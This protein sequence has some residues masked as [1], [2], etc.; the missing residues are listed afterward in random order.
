M[1]FMNYNFGH[2]EWHNSTHALNKTIWS[3]DP[4][5]YWCSPISF[6]PV[7]VPL[8]G[9]PTQPVDAKTLTYTARFKASAAYL[10]TLFP[11]EAF[12]FA[13]PGTVGEISF[14]YTEVEVTTGSGCKH[15][16]VG[17]SLHG[18]EYHKV[19][20]SKV[21]GSFLVVLFESSDDPQSASPV[22]LGLPKVYCN[23]EAV[24]N[25]NTLIVTCSSAGN[26]FLEL[27]YEELKPVCE[28]KIVSEEAPVDCSKP[29][30][31]GS[32]GPLVEEGTLWYRYVP[33]VGGF[34]KA[35]AAYPVFAASASPR[36]PEKAQYIETG[37]GCNIKFLPGDWEGFS[38]VRH[39]VKGL[40]E[41]S[42]YEA[43]R[44]TVEKVDGNQDYRKASKIE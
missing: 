24:K 37:T 12:R 8:D 10:K 4:H 17:L 33:T 14:N 25:D 7:A 34:G 28:T 15:S 11:T 26:T 43:V 13:R 39:V 29:G 42:L 21:V 44:V 41:I 1:E 38:V 19:D 2:D 27:S 9:Q 40:T 5:S 23:I 35:D 6:G 20:G 3:H 18:V 31:S 16:S 30:S 22:D 32:P 36:T